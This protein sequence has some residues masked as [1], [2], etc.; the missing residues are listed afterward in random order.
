[1]RRTW[2]EGLMILVGASIAL[3]PGLSLGQSQNGSDQV[4]TGAKKVGEGAAEAG[5]EAGKKVADA[6]KRAG[7]SAGDIG[8][9]LH[10]GAKGFGEAL[11]DGM[12]QV[13]RTIKNFFTGD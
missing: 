7:S 4:T 9:R 10:E 11:Y 1:M 6:G 3:S 8:D 2:R 12:K 5:K 13:G